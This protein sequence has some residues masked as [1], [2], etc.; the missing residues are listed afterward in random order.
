MVKSSI[1]QLFGRSPIQPLQE[2]MQSIFRAS[3]GLEPFLQA[4]FDGDWV[5]AEHLILLY[6]SM[7]LWTMKKEIRLQ[8]WFLVYADCPQ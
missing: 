8:L 7:I 2:H 5:N 6:P 3:N 1:A 4:A